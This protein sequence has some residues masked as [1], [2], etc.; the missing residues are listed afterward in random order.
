MVTTSSWP[1]SIACF[2]YSIKAETS[3][4]IK[5]SPLPTPTTKGELRR[6]PTISSGLSACIARRVN[7][8]RRTFTASRIAFVRSPLCSLRKSLS[9]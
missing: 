9:K 8:P 4:A 5:F 1:S 6:T 3:D 2:V 7:E